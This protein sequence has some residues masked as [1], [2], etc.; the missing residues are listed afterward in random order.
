MMEERNQR[1]LHEYVARDMS[2][3]GSQKRVRTHSFGTRFH[4]C[5]LTAMREVLFFG[6]N[7]KRNGFH[8]NVRIADLDADR[9][10]LFGTGG[11]L[12]DP[13]QTGT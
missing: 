2:S 8:E 11:L 7:R 4:V 12:Y 10:G 1:L 6:R 5:P 3:E 13:S 9:S